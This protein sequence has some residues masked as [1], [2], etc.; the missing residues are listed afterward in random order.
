MN[1]VSEMRNTLDK[2]INNRLNEAEDWISDLQNTITVSFQAEHQKEK[3]IFKN[4]ESLRNLWNSIKCNNICI[5][6]VT[7]EEKTEQEIENLFVKIMAE[8]FF[9]LMKKKNDTSSGSTKSPI[10]IKPKR[11]TPRHIIIKMANIKDKERILKAAREKQ[12]IATGKFP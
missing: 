10:K 7:K 3:T 4:E 1:T 11:P 12:L 9:N 6:K 2:G 8:N 5:I